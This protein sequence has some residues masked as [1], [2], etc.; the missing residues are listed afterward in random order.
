LAVGFSGHGFM[1]AP[2][3]GRAIADWI[4]TGE[5]VDLDAST[6]ALERFSRG[7]SQHDVVVF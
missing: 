1:H 4:T 3:I 6:F 7:T 5:P 2:A